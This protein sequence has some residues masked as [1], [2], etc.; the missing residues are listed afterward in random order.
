MEVS[1]TD[2][3]KWMAAG[4]W[5]RRGNCPSTDANC[6]RQ[7][8]LW[9]REG[10]KYQ[11]LNELPKGT[12]AAQSSPALLKTSKA[13][14]ILGR[15]SHDHLARVKTGWVC[16][17]VSWLLL[18]WWASGTKHQS[19]VDTDRFHQEIALTFSSWPFHSE[20]NLST[21][22]QSSWGKNQGKVK[23]HRQQVRN[24]QLTGGYVSKKKLGKIPP[25]AYD[26][27]LQGWTK[28]SHSHLQDQAPKSG[29]SSLV[30]GQSLLNIRA[31]RGPGKDSPLT[32]HPAT[33][34]N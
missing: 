24:G 3:S 27:T 4:E 30:Q 34:A 23:D 12:C 26:N 19:A 10:H 16:G 32:G 1:S 21:W 20:G 13:L 2:E 18:A 5:E 14:R 6:P 33:S 15:R 31:N 22:F 11:E 28:A 9:C 17:L 7:S 25:S 29:L 8:A